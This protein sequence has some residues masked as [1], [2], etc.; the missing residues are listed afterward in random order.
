M[1][2]R[3]LGKANNNGNAFRALSFDH[4]SL[5][6][7]DSTSGKIAIFAEKNANLLALVEWMDMGV[8][9]MNSV[10]NK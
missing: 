1:F 2:N 6:E 10:P 7:K 5:W 9:F 3:Q 8:Q 4:S